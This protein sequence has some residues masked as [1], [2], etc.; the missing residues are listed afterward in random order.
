MNELNTKLCE[1]EYLYTFHSLSR[2]VPRVLTF[3]SVEK[4]YSLLKSPFRYTADTVCRT[5]ENAADIT[6]RG[7]R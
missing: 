6:V 4:Y 7:A 1:Y 3:I 5:N 2:Q